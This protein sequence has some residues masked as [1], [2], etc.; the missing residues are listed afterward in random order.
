M[1]GVSG[2]S[3]SEGEIAYSDASYWSTLNVQTVRAFSLAAAIEKVREVP[4]VEWLKPC[5]ICEGR[6]F[7]EEYGP[8]SKSTIRIPCSNCAAGKAYA[9]R[10]P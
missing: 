9:Q 5:E 10:L 7:T 2:Y 8:L 6:G 4:L 1:R 3:T